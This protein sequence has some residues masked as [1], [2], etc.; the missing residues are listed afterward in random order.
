MEQGSLSYMV[1]FLDSEY[2]ISI[3]KQALNER[4]NENCVAYMKAVL[5]E[6]LREHFAPL[7]SN[8]LL[9]GFTRIR[10][11]DSTKFMAPSNLEAHYKSCG[12]DA[13]GSKSGIS[14]QYEYDLKSL[15]NFQGAFP[16]F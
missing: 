3:G 9:P 16:P 12:G 10:I 6:V 2:G 11:K 1:S 13:H 15:F 7:Y 4:F 5:S 8:K 14:I